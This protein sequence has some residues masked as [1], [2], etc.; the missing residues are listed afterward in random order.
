MDIKKTI[1]ILTLQNAI[2]YN[3]KANPGSIM[4]LIFGMDPKLKQKAK[5]ISKEVQ[6]SIKKVNSLSLEEQKNQLKQ[7]GEIKKEKKQ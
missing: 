1:Y 3:G 2:K 7:T 4:G 5:E 6:E